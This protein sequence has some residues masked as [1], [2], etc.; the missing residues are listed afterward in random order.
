MI[1]IRNKQRRHQINSSALQKVVQ[2]LLSAV[3]YPEFDIGIM[4]VSQ[5]AM[6]AYN[7]EYRHKDCAT[8]V[9]SF[10]FYPKLKPR[11]RIK[12]K[13]PDEKNLGDIIICPAFV[14]EQFSDAYDW[15]DKSDKEKRKLLE[16]RIVV[17]I[18]HGLCHLLGYEHET[19]A[20]FRAM[21]R[22]ELQLLQ[23]CSFNIQ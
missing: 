9:L 20:Q 13:N 3:D 5:K 14:V 4:L 16:K 23:S 10:P 21:R 19:A 1:T 18:I 17:L 22:K 8:D 2:T 6:R 7:N 15:D 12:A 11:Q